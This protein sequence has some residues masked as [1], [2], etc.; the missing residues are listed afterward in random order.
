MR[1]ILFTPLA[2]EQYNEWQTENKQVFNKLKKLI[3]E[4]AKTPYEGIGKPEALKHDYTGCW[5]RRI[6]DEHRLI[7]IVKAE[8]IEII[9]CKFHY[10]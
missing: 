1:K 4:T 7:Y 9:A 2:F 10:L 3:K 5:S 8:W 6:T